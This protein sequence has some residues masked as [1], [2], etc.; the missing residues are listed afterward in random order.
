MTLMKE[1]SLDKVIAN[2]SPNIIMQI[3]LMLLLLCGL[4]NAYMGEP[5][6][7]PMYKLTFKNHMVD[8]IPG[9]DMNKDKLKVTCNSVSFASLPNPK[10]SFTFFGAYPMD[11]RYSMETFFPWVNCTAN[12]SHYKWQGKFIAFNSNLECRKE[13]ECIWKIRKKNPFLYDVSLKQFVKQEYF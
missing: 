6:T 13:K 8:D 5:P 11:G 10:A 9:Y 3:I 12:L 7:P 2:I 4:S 1:T